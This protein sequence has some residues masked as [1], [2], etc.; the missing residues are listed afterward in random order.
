MKQKE[1]ESQ[2]AMYLK[3]KSFVGGVTIGSLGGLIGLGGAEFRLPFLVGVL[4]ID[5]L[6]AIILNLLISLITVTFALVFRGID[7][8]V[9]SHSSTIINLLSG[10]LI[11]AWIGVNFATKVNKKTLNSAIFYLLLFISMILFSHI[12]LDFNQALNI[13]HSVQIIVGFILGIGIG[14]VSSLLGVAGGELLI[15]TLVLLYGMDIKTAGTLSLAISLPTLLVGIYKYHKNNRLV[16]ILYFKNIIIFMAIGSILGA[17]L[18]SILFGIVNAV[19]LEILLSLIL[20]IS[21]YKLFKTKEI[22]NAKI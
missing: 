10:T 21:A 4:K 8:H 9:L 13:A 15:P 16:E 19:I 20:L 6:H 7:A 22:N 12:F 5:T 11:G 1:K 18:G 2:I 3:I 14:M 17:L